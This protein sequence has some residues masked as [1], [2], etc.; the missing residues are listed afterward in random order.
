[1]ET[2]Q[3]GERPV[4]TVNFAINGTPTTPS[5]YE[6]KL[7]DPDGTVSTFDQTN[8][9]T[10]SPSAGVV[11]FQPP[12]PFDK[13]GYWTLRVEATAGVFD[14]HE[15]TIEVLPSMFQV[16]SSMVA[17]YCTRENLL[18][19]DIPFSPNE[20][21]RYVNEAADE[22]DGD[23]GAEYNLPLPLDLMPPHVRLKLKNCN[24]ML[25]SGR[26]LLSRASHGQDTSI[27]AY[28]ASLVKE[29]KAIIGAIKTGQFELAGA[30][31]RI[32]QTGGNAPTIINYDRTSAVDTFYGQLGRPG[33]LWR[34]G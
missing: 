30:S 26:L 5:S 13:S 16:P 19:G 25:A 22:M 21:D 2:Y 7:S 11:Q 6:W 10:T 31:R 29:A 14:A 1:M 20:Q 3:V 27:H 4:F 17:R 12:V 8:P 32:A 23:I 18:V 24:A 9:A 33:D 15:Q 34:P 28:G